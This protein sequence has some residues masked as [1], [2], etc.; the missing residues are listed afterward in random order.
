[1]TPRPATGTTPEHFEVVSGTSGNVY[2][3]T[4]FQGGA[5]TCNCE[6]GLR[7]GGRCS[8]I[9][10]AIAFAKT[11]R[12]DAV[13]SAGEAL[14]ASSDAR[15]RMQGAAGRSVLDGDAQQDPGGATASRA[16]VLRVVCSW[17][18]RA[19]VEGDPG[20]PTSHGICPDCAPAVRRSFGLKPRPST[21]AAA[22][23]HQE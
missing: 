11:E 20:A 14:P 12:V 7:Q 2:R 19:L 6:W 15:C 4:P 1:V 8:H 16:D 13:L 22:A 21:A 9:L 3:V 23:Q 10:A 17:C 18:K 5:V